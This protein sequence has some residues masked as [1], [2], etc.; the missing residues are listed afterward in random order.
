MYSFQGRLS[1]WKLLPR[2]STRLCWWLIKHI[3]PTSGPDSRDS[4]RVMFG[5]F[6][7]KQCKPGKTNQPTCTKKTASDFLTSGFCIVLD[8]Y[9]IVGLECKYVVL[10]DFCNKTC[11]YKRI[12]QNIQKCF[13]WG[14]IQSKTFSGW[15]ISYPLGPLP[16]YY[17]WPK[18][19]L[20]LLGEE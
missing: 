14:I 3:Q 9:V 2:E 18:L 1:K 20:H 16:N 11:K 10:N 6:V 19:I 13:I 5:L 17:T 7:N 12:L 8:T 15:H 4:V